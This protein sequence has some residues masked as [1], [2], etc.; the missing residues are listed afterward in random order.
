MAASKGAYAAGGVLV[1]CCC[2]YGITTVVALN[3]A[4]KGEW[5]CA[6]NSGILACV[7]G[8]FG[9]GLAFAAYKLS[10]GPRM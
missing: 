9:A 5:G 1:L 8:V 2:V 4:G 6:R 10:A 3:C 7:T